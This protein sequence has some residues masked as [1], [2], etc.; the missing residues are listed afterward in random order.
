[1]I[2]GE[3]LMVAGDEGAFLNCVERLLTHQDEAK[4]MG[5]RARVRIESDYTWETWL[6]VLDEVISR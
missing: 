6:S 3:E 5:E 2:R 4:K 1:A